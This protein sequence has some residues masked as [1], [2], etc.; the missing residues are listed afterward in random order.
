MATDPLRM[1]N[2]IMIFIPPNGANVVQGGQAI[3]ATAISTP[4]T[5]QYIQCASQPL[6]SNQFQ[7]N[8]PLGPLE[9]FLKAETKT[10]AAIQIIIG[11]IHIGFGAVSA[12][13]SS[14]YI[15]VSVLGGYPFWGGLCFIA[16]GS[17]SVSAEKNLNTCLM[18]FSVGMNIASAILASI[19]II[20]FIV[21][22]TINP[23]RYYTYE[24]YT[25]NAVGTGLCVMLFLFTLLEICITISAARFRCQETC[26]SYDMTMAFIPYTIIGNGVL[27]T[28]NNPAPPAYDQAMLSPN[29]EG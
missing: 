27:P 25:L 21:Q 22:M 20:L 8:R 29:V 13:I 16:S 14:P 24:S 9:K 5:I 11:L 6:G 2:G 19:G 23:H 12:V 4:G 26:F 1:Q 17:I 7:Q 28:E 15:N 3:P 18:K 10:L